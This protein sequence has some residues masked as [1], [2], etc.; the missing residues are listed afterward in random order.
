LWR[1]HATHHSAPRLYWLNASRFHF[2]DIALNNVAAFVP[3][4]AL[5]AG[6]EVFVL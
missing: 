1:F 3:L 5:G 2:V 6:I 4:V